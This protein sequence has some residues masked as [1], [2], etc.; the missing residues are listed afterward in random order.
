MRHSAAVVNI[1][2]FYSK[3]CYHARL[4]K[5]DFSLRH[6]ISVLLFFLFTTTTII[7]TSNSRW[8][9]FKKQVKALNDA[10]IDFFILNLALTAG[11]CFCSLIFH[12]FFSSFS[13]LLSF[14]E[15]NK[16]EEIMS[17]RSKKKRAEIARI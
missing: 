17:S 8:I 11:F 6:F 1:F 14:I 13:F 12:R 7:I 10:A 4:I 3:N 2:L 9:H 15:K 5:D 16:E